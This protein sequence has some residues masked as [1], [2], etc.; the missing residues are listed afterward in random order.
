M[1]CDAENEAGPHSPHTGPLWRNV[2]FTAI[3]VE[4]AQPGS[5]WG[6]WGGRRPA[7]QGGPG[8]CEL[9]LARPVGPPACGLN[10]S[11]SITRTL[12]PCRTPL[13][14][15]PLCSSSVTVSGK[16]TVNCPLV[17]SAWASTCLQ[18]RPSHCP[19]ST[20]ALASPLQPPGLIA[21]LGPF[22][23][24]CLIPEPSSQTPAAATIS[25]TDRVLF[26]GSP[27][28]LRPGSPASL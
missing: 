24:P 14:L 12:I 5:R 18:P 13:L 26:S 6:R 3:K 9:S 17:S 19:Q 2:L 22:G 10:P 11:R 25:A 20:R 15:L 21:A 23:D 8:W 7:P 28:F 4:G 16:D 27:S 1:G